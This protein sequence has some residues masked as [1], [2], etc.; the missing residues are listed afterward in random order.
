M[1]AVGEEEDNDDDDID[2][3]DDDTVSSPEDDFK[4]SMQSVRLLLEH[5]AKKVSGGGNA[6]HAFV[7]ECQEL[8]R[9][10]CKIPVP[11]AS[12]TKSS[13]CVSHQI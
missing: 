4:N 6:L 1:Q 12:T 9:H 7:G 13:D 8:I 2:S 5:G 10:R 11:P 3:S